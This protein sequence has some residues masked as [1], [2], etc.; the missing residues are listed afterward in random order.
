MGPPPPFGFRGGFGFAGGRGRGGGHPGMPMPPANPH[1]IRYRK[2]FVGG[3]PRELTDEDF[4][5]FFGRF[6]VI[7]D[8]VII[9][10][11]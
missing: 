3:L 7:T 4:K 2:V 10:D 9:K 6:G 8:A 11:A 5:E 1:D